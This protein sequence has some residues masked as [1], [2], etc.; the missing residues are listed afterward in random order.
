MTTNAIEKAKGNNYKVLLTIIPPKPNRDGEEI[1]NELP[2]RGIPLFATGD[3]ALHRP[4]KR[5][6]L[7]AFPSTMP[8]TAG[9]KTLG[10]ITSTSERRFPLEYPLWKGPG[11]PRQAPALY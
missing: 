2:G 6:R 3:S 7:P 1:R 4:I 10:E 8:M 11:E 9:L 5:Q